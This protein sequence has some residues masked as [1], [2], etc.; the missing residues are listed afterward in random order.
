MGH[1]KQN[2][3]LVDVP[4]FMDQN[5]PCLSK[6][7]DNKDSWHERDI[8]EMPLEKLLVDSEVFLS[9]N[10]VVF[11]IELDD[12]IDQQKWIAV[13]EYLRNLFCIEY[14]FLVHVDLDSGVVVQL[15]VQGRGFLYALSARR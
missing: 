5:S 9:H 6:C 8:G 13:R 3:N 1:R 11:C 15:S 12:L 7:F 14:R 2:S 4:F 10:E